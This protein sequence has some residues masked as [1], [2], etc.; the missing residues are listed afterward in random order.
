MQKE[1]MKKIKELIDI[2]GSI[3][4]SELYKEFCIT[5]TKEERTKIIE[6]VCHLINRECIIYTPNKP[7]NILTSCNNTFH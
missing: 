5:D 7:D 6:S 2:K 3:F 1:L 4:E